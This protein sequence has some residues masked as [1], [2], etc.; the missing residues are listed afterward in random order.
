MSATG[1]LIQFLLVYAC[2]RHD[3][4]MSP[5]LA[6]IN[7]QA[8]RLTLGSPRHALQGGAQFI[9]RADAE[10][11]QNGCGQGPIEQFRLWQA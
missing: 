3:Q 6:L 1:E 9:E 8:L 7:V 5:S 2:F 4:K 11:R 10:S